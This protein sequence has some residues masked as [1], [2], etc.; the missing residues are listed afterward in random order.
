MRGRLGCAS[1]NSWSLSLYSINTSFTMSRFYTQTPLHK[2]SPRWQTKKEYQRRNI[3]LGS[4]W[5]TGLRYSSKQ[6]F[7]MLSGTWL[8]L[9]GHSL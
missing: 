8:E 1:V 3:L 7:G 2:D 9:P 4:I 5:T 6:Y